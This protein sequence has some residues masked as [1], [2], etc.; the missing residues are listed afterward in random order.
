[1]TSSSSDAARYEP[2][3]R[4]EA[5]SD[6]NSDDRGRAEDPQGDM[7][8]GEA[9]SAADARW[10]A[11]L[12]DQARQRKVSLAEAVAESD[13][14]EIDSIDESTIG[15]STSIDDIR[16]LAR[17]ERERSRVADDVAP[18]VQPE[19]GRPPSGL[20][21]APTTQYRASTTRPAQRG[22]PDVSELRVDPEQR[23]GPRWQAPPRLEG[24]VDQTEPLVARKN[25]VQRPTDWRVIALA[26]VV[27][28]LI[29]AIVTLVLVND[30]AP[31]DPV[32]NDPDGSTLVEDSSEVPKQSDGDAVAS[33]SEREA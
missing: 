16:R 17:E 14:P 20:P 28:V 24:A 4:A 19:P 27:A 23:L 22:L 30:S 2:P 6:M 18:P 33:R 32:E 10:L 7:T 5:A 31:T 12:R 9:T 21:S 11:D 8:G 15:S 26:I 25:T 29:G 13:R 1:M 3:K